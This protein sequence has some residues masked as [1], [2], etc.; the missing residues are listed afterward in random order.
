MF[1][2]KGKTP[3]QREW[4]QVCRRERDFLEGRRKKKETA[5]NQLIAGKVPD[6]L[7]STLDAA[8]EK[9]FFLTFDKGTG[10]IEKTYRKEEIE[11]DYKINR[12]ADELRKSRRSLGVFTKKAKGAGRANVALSG[13]SGIGTG[14]LGIGLPDIPI[15]TAMILKCIYEIA[16]HYGYEYES[17][18]ERYFVL[19]IIQG[20]ASYGADLDEI[21]GK[22][23]AYIE[24]PRLPEGYEAQK[25]VAAASRTLSGELLYMK[26]LQ[27]IPIA[28]AVGGAYDVIYMR[29]IAQFAQIKYQK[30]FL[31]DYQT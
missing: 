19:L 28:G 30:R 21:N 1:V 4:E 3:F 22:I 29:Q 9:A 8:F 14:L 11:K 26:F 24:S 27:G 6:K 20:A 15:F 16:L 17:L 23:D 10:V 31:I 7:R 5:L 18:Q 25:Q 12:Y 13:V 2:K